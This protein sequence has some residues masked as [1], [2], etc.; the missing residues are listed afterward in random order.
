MFAHQNARQSVYGWCTLL[1]VLM[2][3]PLL[4]SCGS[5]KVYTAD[6]TIVHRDSIYNVS[7]VRVFTVRNEAVVGDGQIVDLK[8]MERKAF[9][10][11]LKENGGSVRVQHI[12]QL[13]DQEMVYQRTDVKSWSD[14]SRMNK[15]FNSAG[16]SITK[17]LADKKKTQ[18]KLK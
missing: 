14:L 13:D 6:K 5:T 4:V 9:E 16:K 2:V 12:F 17:F 15:R 8:G 18:L 7:N 3:V 1:A 11:L 10:N